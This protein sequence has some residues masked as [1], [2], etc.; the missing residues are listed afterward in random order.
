M[1][2]KVLNVAYP[3]APVGPD[4]IGGAEQIL[5]QLD[6][7][8]VEAGHR[9]IVLACEG[10]QTDGHLV[11]VPKSN[12]SITEERR[13]FVHHCHREAI[14]EILRSSEVDLVHLHGIDFHCY[15]PEGNVPTLVTLHLPLNW[16]AREPF[17][18]TRPN[19]FLQP[20]SKS[21][22]R[23][24][25]PEFR[26]LPPI[27]NGVP[28]EQFTTRHAKRNFAV[29]LGRICPEKGFHIAIEAA[30]QAKIPLLLAGD[31]FPFEAH[32]QY[33]Q[34][35][36]VPRLDDQRLFVGPADF[37]RK[38]RL[39]SAARC[40]LVPSLVDETSSLVAM[41]ALACGTPVIAFP[42]GALADIIEHGKTGF[43]VNDL[44]EMTAAIRVVHHL[45]PAACRHTAQSRFSRQRMTADYMKLYER[46]VRDDIAFDGSY[47]HE[48]NFTNPHVNLGS[49]RWTGS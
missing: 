41:E 46:I 43:L 12:N 28:V 47:D 32:E 27:E 9:S 29:C 36:L 40:L 3:F 34:D 14:Q 19:L 45:D 16:Y 31:V 35:E 5:T 25:R 7:A 38:R 44:R 1:K 13:A 2:L 11:T 37:V 17:H 48:N 20:V 8:L 49:D 30:K 24:A 21:Q 22:S 6:I 15:L 42:N 10:S 18:S 4:A 39:L 33:F 23:T 26:L